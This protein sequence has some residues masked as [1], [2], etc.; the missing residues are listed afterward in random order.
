MKSTVSPDPELRDRGVI[1]LREFEV[2][3][4]SGELRKNG[5]KLKLTVQP[6]QVL[7]MLLERP[8]E[9]VTREEIRGRLWPVDTFVDFDH[10]L[11]TAI[12]KIREALDDSAESPRF[13]ETLP[14]RGYRFIGPVEAIGLVRAAPSPVPAEAHVNDNEGTPARTAKPLRRKRWTLAVG[15]ALAI[16]AVALLGR[17][18]RQRLAPS[19]ELAEQRLTTN[20]AE[21]PVWASA[22]S[23]DGR[24]L[25]Y[26]DA[27]GI[28]LRVIETAETHN[29]P[30]P[31]DSQINKLAWFPSGDR[32][33]ASGE[34]GQ[35]RSASLWSI[36]VLGGAPQKLQDGG[37]DGNVFED[38]SG[39]VF[40]RGHGKEI[41]QM[42][43]TG[44]DARKLIT[45]SEGERFAT[46]TVV[47]GRL[48]YSKLHAS[49]APWGGLECEIES[50][51]LKGGP[52][53]DL[54]PKLRAVSWA[55]LPNGRL[56]FSRS[57]R[58]DPI[59][60][61]GASGNFGLIFTPA[62]LG[63]NPAQSLIGPILRL[64]T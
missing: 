24:Y 62:K 57:K 4:R 59:Q 12:N 53:T 50:R 52:S 42:G 56:I 3:L 60:G 37:A 8:G 9:L 29:L 26:S 43:P 13:V 49:E 63:A 28:H 33:L 44:E 21:I 40:V 10:S 1:R 46:P 36:S 15:S 32:L 23:P 35:P 17:Y 25:A 51:G 14:R 11:N 48:W 47:Q 20:S 5:L 45:A 16:L 39:I 54:L 6:F 31:S 34:A 19:P 22:I 18:G 27:L 7:A 58:A 38:G 41:W 55:L 30:T 61:G 64:Q 2:D